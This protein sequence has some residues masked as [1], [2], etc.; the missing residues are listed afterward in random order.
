MCGAPARPCSAEPVGIVPLWHQ[1]GR[2][3]REHLLSRCVSSVAPGRWGPGPGRDP[4]RKFCS[5]G[6]FQLLPSGACSRCLVGYDAQTPDFAPC[7]SGLGV[8]N[9]Q[10]RGPPSLLLKGGR[11][12]GVVGQAGTCTNRSLIPRPHRTQHLQV[13]LVGGPWGPRSPSHAPAPSA[14]LLCPLLEML[15]SPAR[16]APPIRHTALSACPAER[17]PEHRG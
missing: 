13:Q 11:S 15:P 7:F 1:C 16:Q 3:N 10:A 4:G 14:A 5:P 9:A 8:T 17:P 2:P 6:F 12:G